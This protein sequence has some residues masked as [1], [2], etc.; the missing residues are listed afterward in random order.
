MQQEFPHE[1]LGGANNS[2]DIFIIF[3]NFEHGGDVCF[4]TLYLDSEEIL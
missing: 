3:S 4:I 2:L 1:V